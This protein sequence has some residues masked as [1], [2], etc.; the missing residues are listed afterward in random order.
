MRYAIVA[1]LAHGFTVLALLAVVAV[2]TQELI[3]YGMLAGAGVL[4]LARFR[5][6]RAAKR[7]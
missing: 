6:L 1:S 4:T 2:L 3:I 5:W 7:A